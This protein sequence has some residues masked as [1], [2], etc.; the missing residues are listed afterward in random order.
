MR[1]GIVSGRPQQAHTL[2]RALSLEPAH[3]VMWIADS[4]AAVADRCTSHRPELVLLNL[5]FDGF[6]AV[7]AVRAVRASAPC[8]ILIVT[9]S[10][11]EC[12]PVGDD[13]SG[14]VLE[15]VDIPMGE[16]ATVPR[17]AAV[18]LAR[19]DA[20]TRLASEQ[21]SGRAKGNVAGS[22]LPSM[23]LVA[24]GASAGGPTA[25][26]CV[27]KNL[28]AD[29]PA[30]IVVV[31]HVGDEF[32]EGMSAWLSD[33]TGREV[34]VAREGDRPN[35]GRV[36]LAAATGHLQLRGDGRVS[37]TEE[38]RHT[39]YRP[40]VDVF[41][42]SASTAWPG[43]VVGV[44]LTGMGRDGALG[45]KALRDKG[46]HTIAQDEASSAVYGMPKAAATLK[47]AIEIRALH[48]IAPRLV[49]LFAGKRLTLP[50]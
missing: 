14:G 26:A 2:Y 9:D 22:S 4:R 43:R 18:L 27:L 21:A 10:G 12:A 45:L 47:A 15:S 7:N 28:P 29:F 3:H 40:S 49:D 19:I 44:L 5:P 24:I 48:E 13:P 42:H 41:F 31:Q 23:P 37:Y 6:D 8:P 46:H 1:I 39:A 33:Q 30:G 20:L 32:V 34:R 36:L 16:S 17:V 38:P 11:S 35:A 25:V 50:V